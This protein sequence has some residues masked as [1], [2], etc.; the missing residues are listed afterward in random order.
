MTPE[1]VD[2]RLDWLDEQRRKDA[3]RLHLLDQRL[4][5]IEES[6]AQQT[7]QLQD[8]ASESTRLSAF[9]AR[10]SQFDDTLSKHRQEVSRL[11]GESEEARSAKEKLLE[12]ARK[13]DQADLSKSLA[14]LRN[15]L[16]RLADIRQ[17]FD[18]RR[19]EEV[20]L[21]R[22]LDG[23]SKS[24]ADLRARD[25][26]RARWMT[27]FEEARKQ[28]AKRMA[29]LQAEVTEVRSRLDATRGT[30]DTVEDR[31]RRLEVRAG[32]LS[33]GEAERREALF[34]WMEQQNLKAVEFERSAKE[35]S[36]RFE[37]F[38]DMAR[39]LEE[40][41]MAYDETY[42]ALRQQRQ[43]L[44]ALLERLERRITEVSEIQRLGEDRFK[45]EWA[46]FQADDQ[47]RWNTDKLARDE[48][49][50]DHNR[51]HDRLA[52]DLEALKASMEAAL[53]SLADLTGSSQQRMATL[54]AL[55]R[56]WAAE[57]EAQAERIR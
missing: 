38:E 2:K 21:T 7:R 19:E 56:E 15:D 29:D 10:V 25:E 34:L 27:S 1:Q 33:A 52:K 24:M 26:D 5:G 35:W 11:L 6:L 12:Q 36:K 50:R 14:E 57:A 28:E 48:Q 17:A 39:Q 9:A 55:F 30:I 51:L 37:S 13:R 3:E 43:D 20:R 32:D 45:Q 53:R 40:R 49:W 44:D 54:L 47:K 16:K 22:T 42:R 41:M 8:L 18:T 23:V 31:I 46:E 4:A